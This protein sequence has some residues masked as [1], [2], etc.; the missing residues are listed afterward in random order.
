MTKNNHF[1]Q[2]DRLLRQQ[3]SDS[4]GLNEAAVFRYAEMLAQV[5]GSLVVVSD[6]VK[7]TSRIFSG[8]FARR[9]GIDG[10]SSENSIWEKEILKLMS[11]TEQEIKVIAELRF[12]HYLR[13][14][15]KHRKSE[16]FLMSKL[17]FN[18]SVEVL[19]RMYYVYDEKLESVRCAI[20]IYGPLTVDF[21][22]QSY[23][24]NTATGIKEEL[25]TAANEAV[26]SKR[27]RQ[28]LQLISSGMKSIEIAEAL[29][30]SKNTVSRH[31]QEI[32]A[33]MQV[34]N[35]VEACRLAKS[36]GLI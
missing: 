13:R 24:V 18:E 9:L 23:A 8:V 20:C 22:G 30:I 36:M 5:E 29:S 19:H 35:S 21:P 2:L 14:L 3:A 32:L 34:K 33:K 26:I 7:G 31:R 28:I 4:A 6:L 17:R 27:E 25:T 1:N 15:P 10:Y 11:E 12:F 16:Y